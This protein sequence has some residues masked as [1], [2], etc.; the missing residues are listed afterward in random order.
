[1]VPI[2]LASAG[3]S[4]GAAVSYRATQGALQLP[5]DTLIGGGLPGPPCMVGR[6][7]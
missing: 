1:M 3:P 6:C 7:R 2:S 4:I 5:W